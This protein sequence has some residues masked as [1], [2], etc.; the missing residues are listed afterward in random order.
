MT[1]LGLLVL[2]WGL[3]ICSGSSSME[4]RESDVD[5]DANRNVTQLIKSKGYPVEE[6]TVRTRD[7]YLLK[8]VRIP[9]GRKNRRRNTRNRRVAFLQHGFLG[10]A[11][12]WVMNFPSQSLGYILADEGYDV[13]LGNQRGNIYARRHVRYSPRSNRF[14]NFS[15][16]E[17]AKYDTPNSID[18]VLK[19]T[20]QRQ[21]YYVGWSQGCMIAFAFLSENP[22]YNK[23][24]AIFALAP[25]A[26]VGYI[27]S[28][29]RY[30]A[31]LSNNLRLL[32]SALG[33]RE[34][35]PNNYITKLFAQTVCP[36][37]SIC[38][39]LY[40]Q[41]NGYDIHQLNQSRLPVYFSQLPA[42]ESTKTL[43]H[44]GQMI[45]SKKFQKFDYG[46]I[47]NMQ[48]YKRPSPPEYKLEKIQTPIAIFA[49]LNDK[50]ADTKDVNILRSR[51]PNLLANHQVS[52]REW[53]H[54]DFVF[55][56]E[57]K[58]YVYDHLLRVMKTI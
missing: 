22:R 49:G 2:C 39:N 42:G 38:S 16:D 23:I 43:I 10:S 32:F 40:F 25:T 28:P 56:I 50:L 31:P 11:S 58:K 55:A 1:A 7:G 57:T 14:W 34:L 54:L 3:I 45:N 48:K 8:L 6:Y 44:Y 17:H 5:P 35:L 46:R 47:K 4:S 19:K 36:L 52:L 37:N 21:L 20:G 33:Q 13:W 29:I 27:E 24:K 30:L 26:T 15:I 12:D 41:I 51:I 9:Y 18:F 53:G